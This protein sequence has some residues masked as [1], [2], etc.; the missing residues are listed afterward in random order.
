ML[1]M[2]VL[3]MLMLL[4]VA[5]GSQDYFGLDDWGI[6]D[7]HKFLETKSKSKIDI[8]KLRELGLTNAFALLN[9]EESKYESIIVQGA[10]FDSKEKKIKRTITAVK[11]LITKDPIDFYEW[12]VMNERLCD[13]WI[14]PLAFGSP[15]P[16]LVWVRY[17]NTDTRIDIIDNEI[18]E[19]SGVS[20]WFQ[21]LF[22]PSRM[23]WHSLKTFESS[24]W[25][26]EIIHTTLYV[27]GLLEL[28]IIVCLIFTLLGSGPG[29][30]II[31]FFEQSNFIGSFFG[32]IGAWVSYYVMYYIVPTFLVDLAFNL[33]IFIILPVGVIVCIC[34]FFFTL[35]KELSNN[36]T[37]KIE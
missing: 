18:D 33:K 2:W 35:V 10:L 24:T 5:V 37:K 20:F 28:L 32:I 8:E 21:L 12:R 26:D 6:L 4:Q 27:G 23:L 31:L 9:L 25:A 13:F 3:V 17:F 36:N 22:C 19:I 11:H 15:R 7:I 30:A 34:V 29:L 1:G 14:L 16:L